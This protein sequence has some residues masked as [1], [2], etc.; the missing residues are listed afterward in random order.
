VDGSYAPE[1]TDASA[2]LTDVEIYLPLKG[3][4]DFD[5]ERARIQK[6]I[7]RTAADLEKVEKKLGNASFVEK[8]PAEIIEK[9][10]QKRDGF[11]EIL[12]KLRESLDNLG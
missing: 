3:L 10:K 1:K 5:K 2:I 11:R 12:G 8:A 9:E 4:I 7:D 6:E